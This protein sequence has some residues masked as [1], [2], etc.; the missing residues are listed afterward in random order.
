M[1]GSCGSVSA[2][3]DCYVDFEKR[4]IRSRAIAG[5]CSNVETRALWRALDTDRSGRALRRRSNPPL[6]RGG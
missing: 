5:R 6:K 4:K 3:D 1:R 2:C